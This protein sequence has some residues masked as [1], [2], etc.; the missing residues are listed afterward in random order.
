MKETFLEKNFHEKNFFRKTFVKKKGDASMVATVLLIM[1]AIVAGVMVT[2]FSQKSTQK[3]S[4]KI[5]EIGTS[6]D[7]N[8]IRLSLYINEGNIYIK[9]E[10]HLALTELC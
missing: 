1:V 8:D 5:V 9:T 2:S 6:V 7:C 10:A 3:V 4:D